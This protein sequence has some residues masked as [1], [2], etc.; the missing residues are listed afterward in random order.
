MTPYYEQD[1]IVIYHADC[2]D[3]V[4]ALTRN[5]DLLLTDPPYG[6]GRDGSKASTGSH[7]GRKAYDFRGWDS[8][9]P[10][11]WLLEM[12]RWRT[13]HQIVWGGNYFIDA[14]YPTMKWL[15]W[16]KGQRID[17]SDGELAWTSLPGALRIF[18]LNRVAIQ[19]DGAVHPTQKPEELMRWCI[20][21]A[22][23]TKSV[24]DPFMGSGSTLVAAKRLGL[25]A[26]GIERE[27]SYC[28]I[29]AKRLAQ[30][31]LFA[32]EPQSPVI[33]GRSLWEESE[34]A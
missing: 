34:S 7:G 26:V 15:V 16:D 23:G 12:L 6:I 19:T 2:R 32:P 11:R 8:D 33:G 22:D 9:R 28:E 30:G 14:L 4:P 25:I 5:Y 10:E 18:T 3:F 1:G 20:G 13:N 21:Q 31:V 29:A 27:E 24:L 17:Q